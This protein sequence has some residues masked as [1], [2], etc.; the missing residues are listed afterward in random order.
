[1]SEAPVPWIIS[2]DDHVIEPPHMWQSRLP[3]KFRE[4]GPQVVRLPWK[5]GGAFRGQL[6]RPG[7]AALRSDFWAVE[8]ICIAVAKIEAAAGLPPEQVTHEPVNYADMRPGCYQ[9][10]ER[11]ADMDAARSSALCA[12]PNMVRFAGPALP[13]DEDKELAL[14]CMRAYNDWMV[15]EWAGESGGRL[16]PLCIVPSVGPDARG[17]GGPPQRGARCTS[18]DLHRAAVAFSGCRAS[19]TRTATGCPSSRPATRPAR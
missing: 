4:R 2:V 9:V 17:R 16:I 12:F 1:M 19:T 11:L 5:I 18:G 13:V 7:P 14:A 8:D 15:E 10:K 3:A 6:L